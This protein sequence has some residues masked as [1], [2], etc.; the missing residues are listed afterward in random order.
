[1]NQLITL[2]PFLLA[3]T[4]AHGINDSKPSRQHREALDSND[5]LDLQTF[6]IYKCEGMHF[7][8]SG[9]ASA[10]GSNFVSTVVEYD[11]DLFV[12]S[13]SVLT[14]ALAKLQHKLLQ[15]VG[16]DLFSDCSRRLADSAA[17]LHIATERQLG[18]ATVE[19]ITSAPSDLVTIGS[20]CIIEDDSSTSNTTEC[21]PV[22]GYITAY[23]EA[24]ENVRRLSEEDSINAAIIA[25]VRSA[26]EDGVLT[27]L[28]DISGV[29]YLGD[30]D[31]FTFASAESYLED[32]TP[33]TAPPSFWDQSGGIII[34]S[35]VGVV[36]MA[37]VAVFLKKRRSSSRRKNESEAAGDIS[38][39][40]HG[41]VH[42]GDMNVGIE[43]RE[44][45]PQDDKYVNAGCFPCA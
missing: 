37:L 21:Y 39:N 11:Y 35:S 17:Y 38:H 13:D 18:G 10:A 36:A 41:M 6:Q 32:E 4:Q 16:S 14:S 40:E 45:P 19:E 27:T 2:A 22:T 9:P 23:Y 34:G 28:D 7:D 29:Q 15:H 44:G 24:V 33:R 30:R 25:S 12:E 3:S 42:Y 20:S 1:M 26:M 8:W 43:Q 31:T 5:L